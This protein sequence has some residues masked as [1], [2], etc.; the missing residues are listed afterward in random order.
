MNTENPSPGKRVKGF[1]RNDVARRLLL[2][3]MSVLAQSFL[4]LV[5][6]HFMALPL[7]SAGHKYLVVLVAVL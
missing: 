3:L 7:F 2:L 6:C 5:R 4:T 1:A